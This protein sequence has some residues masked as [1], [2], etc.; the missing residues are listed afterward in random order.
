LGKIIHL[1][2]GD[3]TMPEFSGSQMS[4]NF[5]PAGRAVKLAGK[6]I[7][8]VAKKIAQRKA[9]D[10]KRNVDVEKLLQKAIKGPDKRTDAQKRAAKA[11]FDR[12][13]REP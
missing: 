12:T 1:K 13:F 7:T 3:N 5:L 4:L 8:E 2:Q 10:T 11:Y 6:G 9:V